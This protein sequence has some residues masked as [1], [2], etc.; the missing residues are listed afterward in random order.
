MA[1]PPSRLFTITRGML[2]QG[3]VRVLVLAGL[4]TGTYVSMLNTTLQPFTLSLGLGLTELGILQALGSRLGGL[5]GSLVQPFAG[6]FSD[7]Q[8]RRVVVILGSATTIFSM[9]FF[10][11]SATTHSWVPLLLGY[12]LFGLSLLSSPAS[13]AIIAES[14]NLEP[15]KMGAAFSAVFFFNQIPGVIMAFV[16]GVVADTLGYSLIFALAILLESFNLLLYLTKLKETRNSGT[17]VLSSARAPFSLRSAVR[18]PRSFLGFF[19]TFAAD[20]FSFGI[21]GTILYGMLVRQYGYSNTDIGLIVGTL[22]L[23]LILA[24]YPAAR[25]LLRVGPRRSLAFS[26]FLSVLLLIGWNLANSLPLFLLLSVLFGVS[27]ATWVPAQQSLLMA[28]APPEERGSLG[29][30][31]AA[32]RGLV[33]FPAPIVGGVLYDSFGYH[34]PVTASLLG[35]VVALIMILKLLPETHRKPKRVE[36]S[37][38][39]SQEV[40]LGDD[41]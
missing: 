15:E 14:V 19:A 8:G 28:H 24:Q 22:S 36:S 33:A 26:E 3:N 5:S 29:G 9:L 18:I 27:I 40:K 38:S 11:I 37:A 4:V 17:G 1:R 10:F 20:A 30:K 41:L 21:T 16:A 32:F 7:V 39:P 6:H 31:L 13:T 2:G 35:I 12:L 23:A 34:A 25:F